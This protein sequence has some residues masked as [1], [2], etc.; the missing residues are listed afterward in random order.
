MW[1]KRLTT[2]QQGLTGQT[3]KHRRRVRDYEERSHRRLC[4]ILFLAG[5][6]LLAVG[7]SYSVTRA[8]LYAR[9]GKAVRQETAALQEIYHQPEVTGEEL[10]TVTLNP[11]VQLPHTGARARTKVL[12]SVPYGPQSSQLVQRFARL[13]Q[14]NR[15]IIGWLNIEGM[16]DE[17]VVQRDNEYYL[18]RDYQGYH[19]VN[20]AIFAD[21]DC[22][23]S[24][25]PYTIVLYGH[26]M[27]TGAMFGGLQRFG[28]QGYY[29]AHPFISFDTV[30]E[31]G[32]YVVF[33]VMTAGLSP[34]KAKYLDLAKLSSSTVMWREEAIAS[35]QEGS[36]YT[37][38]IDVA[39]DDQILLLVTCASED[40]EE[41]RIVAARR[42]R[43]GEYETA[44]AALVR[45]SRKRD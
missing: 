31:S 5:V 39:A 8:A 27:K 29:H 3:L 12:R 11:A 21:E 16:L 7:L 43:E 41:R 20:G 45:Q 42:V 30:H 37:R 35:L 2:E 22:N 32:R 40:R 26:N 14:Q 6:A 44:L 28:Q 1:N 19:N 36:E 10:P 9:Q 33:S 13:R 24:T 25:R 15:D 4:Y 38:T 17:A 23:F 34:Q 18:R